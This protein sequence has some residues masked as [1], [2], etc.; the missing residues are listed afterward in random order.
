[1]R[2]ALC[3]DEVFLE[4]VAP[5]GHPERPERLRA[6]MAA[7]ERLGP[8][9]ARFA[10]RQAT[11]AEVTLAHDAEFVAQLAAQLPHHSGYLDPDTYFSARS[12]EVALLAAGA[13]VDA[14][15][16]VM[17]GEADHA[18]VFARPP[19]HHAESARAMGFCL[20]NNAAIAAATARAAGAARVAVVDWDVHH[21]NG[22]QQIFWTDPS[23]LY[24][25]VHQ[26][27]FYPGSGAS[28]EI[29]AG[30]GRGFTINAPLPAHMGPVEF[31]YVFDRLFVPALAAFDPALIVIS[32]GFD[33]HRDDP[34]GEMRLTEAA[35]FQLAARLRALGR[36]LVA[37][38]EGGYDLDAVGASSAATL[39]V[40]RGTAAP[41]ESAED[42]APAAQ[43]VCAQT[44]S[45]L[46]GTPLELARSA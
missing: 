38:L 22:T 16:L 26:Y 34:L 1:V 44:I 2:A 5:P 8:G 42:A 11:L 41:A 23:V 31:A 20:L 9:F 10:P 14:V 29:G 21:G 39:E 3:L 7:V 40:L 36:P 18:A 4:H 25:S 13:S 45:A 46:V 30:P 12:W 32:A 28:S 33:A 17:S 37:I 15:H 35:Y 24:M 27:P 19:G 6:I 43:K